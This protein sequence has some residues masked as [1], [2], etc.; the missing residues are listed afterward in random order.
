[1][2]EETE[3]VKKCILSLLLVLA[4]S[5][6]AF[7][8]EIPTDTVVQNLNGSQQLIKTY[9]LLPDADPQALIEAPFELEGYAYTFADIVKKTSVPMTC[10]ST[11]DRFSVTPSLTAVAGT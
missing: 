1:M 2:E 6:G 8:M 7:A 11:P 3:A 4:L 5:T 9:T 10:Q